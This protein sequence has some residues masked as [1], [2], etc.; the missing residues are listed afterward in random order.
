L[1]DEYK[2]IFLDIVYMWKGWTKEDAIRRLECCGFHARNGLK[3]LEQRSLITIS[4][5]EV[6]GMHD[7]IEEMGKNIGTEATRCLKLYTSRGNLRILMK[8][9][10]KMKK[11]RYL[12]VHLQYDSKSALKFDEASQYFANSLQYLKFENYPFLY[13]LQT[14]QANN[15]VGLE[16]KYSR[17]IQLQKEGE[18]KNLKKLKFLSLS[19]SNLTIFDFRITPNLETLSLDRP[20]LQQSHEL[21]EI[22]APAG[23]LQKV[24][25][26]NLSGCL[27]VSQGSWPVR[28]SREAPFVI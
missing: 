6:L 26:L 20:H 27:R 15:L 1:E 3:V 24:G 10:G 19:N 21:V 7:H 16:V 18:K 2:E 11:L 23:C 4:K 9:L 28:M 17:M 14:F 13:L 12:D 25:Y 8:G 22:D 5:D